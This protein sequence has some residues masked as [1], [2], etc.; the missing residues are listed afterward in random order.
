ME[1]ARAS[2][3]R[4][5]E[6]ETQYAENLAK[7]VAAKDATIAELKKQNALP[8]A[9]HAPAVAAQ[10]AKD[11]AFAKLEREHAAL[12]AEA[13]TLRRWTTPPARAAWRSSRLR[14]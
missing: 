8:E 2:D 4:A 14:P 11:A 13:M 5:R 3:N 12:H 1:V 9:S 6:L 7:V 10:D